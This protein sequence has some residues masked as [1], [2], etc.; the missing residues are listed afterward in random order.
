M[1]V[2]R[3]RYGSCTDHRSLRWAVALSSCFTGCGELREDA[4]RE[5]TEP[6][7]SFVVLQTWP[8]TRAYGHATD[9]PIE[10]C[11]S[12]IVDPDVVHP[13]L[14]NLS[15]GGVNSDSE[16]ELDWIDWRHALGQR[17]QRP[18]CPGSVLQ[19]RPAAKL[20]TSTRYR[21]RVAD[22]IR[23]WS[24]TPIDTSRDPR[25]I[26][27]DGDDDP[28]FYLEFTTAIS[29]DPRP[30]DDTARPPD[31]PLQAPRSFARLFDPGEPF[32]ADSANCSC[33]FIPGHVATARWDLTDI[34]SAYGTLRRSLNADGL[35]WVEPGYPEYSFLIHK[36][37]RDDAGHALPGLN[38][39][40]MPPWGPLTPLELAQIYG[41]I[42]QG[43]H[44]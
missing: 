18:A 12:K 41:W 27:E 39:D 1:R 8:P 28:I 23:A 9:A 38:G 40:P 30:S 2:F 20:R 13:G 26:Y 34:S 37:T 3:G 24:G 31:P 16:V 7:A 36:L 21:V 6:H 33:H 5:E 15:S 35:P 19:I 11:F 43:A 44:P 25:W 42:E 10:L 4:K 32:D 29:D 17:L 14:V 22:A